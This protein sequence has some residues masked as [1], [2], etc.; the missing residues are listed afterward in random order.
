MKEV[1]KEIIASMS[2][3]VI[4]TGILVILPIIWEVY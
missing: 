1:I 2:F 3:G 4:A